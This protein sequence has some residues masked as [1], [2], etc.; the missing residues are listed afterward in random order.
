MDFIVLVNATYAIGVNYSSNNRC[1]EI[2]IIFL[3]I[4]YINI[5]H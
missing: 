4:I 1:D 3:S 2:I 5:L